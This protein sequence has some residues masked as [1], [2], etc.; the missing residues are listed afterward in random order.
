[1]ISYGLHSY[2]LSA[3]LA[4]T[5]LAD[6]SAGQ[7]I[8]DSV[9]KPQMQH[10]H[11]TLSRSGEKSVT[12]TFPFNKTRVIGLAAFQGSAFAAATVGLNTAWYKNYPREKFHFFNDMEEWMQMDKIG[13]VY[14]SYA[15]GKASMEMWRW[16]GIERKKRIW[17]G[18]LSGLAYQTM[19]EALDAHSSQWGW[20]WGDM[21]S[22]VLGS[23]LLISQEMAWNEQ[24]FQLKWSF[25][26]NLY[27]DPQLEARADDI[28]G[29]SRAERMLKDYNAQT[30][31]V[32]TGLRQWLPGSRIPHWLQLS[33]GTGIKGVFGARGNTAYDES[34]NIIFSRGDIKRHREWYLSPDIDLTKIKT[35]NKMLRM[36]FRIFN[37][38]KIPAPALEY[39]NG[40]WS[41]YWLYF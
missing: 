11:V 8:Q 29:K 35:G 27:D 30:Y 2:C 41:F 39:G 32:S 24:R 26:Y 10:G 9:S 14:S 21:G 18:G 5:L 33:V 25:H 23:A 16:T 6:V 31:W 36:L 28:F 37:V 20:S 3:A 38:V 22:N 15:E 13:H 17:I 34:G 19:L 4:L 12:D 40:K 1:M 7:D